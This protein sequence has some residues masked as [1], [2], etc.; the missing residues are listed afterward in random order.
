[1]DEDIHVGIHAH[2]EEE[3]NKEDIRE[4]GNMMVAVEDPCA[5]RQGTTH[6]ILM[7]DEVLIQR[8]GR[9]ALAEVAVRSSYCSRR[10]SFLS[11]TGGLWMGLHLVLVVVPKGCY[12]DPQLECFPL[13]D[14]DDQQ[15]LPIL[16]STHQQ[17]P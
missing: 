3:R 4:L 17:R 14:D 13:V 2:A 8:V 9:N 11:E 6:T 16:P 10:M 1:M 12:P 15:Q 5:V 7:K